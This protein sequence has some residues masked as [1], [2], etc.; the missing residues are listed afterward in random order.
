MSTGKSKNVHV[1]PNSAL[2][3]SF[4]C[5]Q[6]AD[7]TKIANFSTF[8]IY[9]HALDIVYYDKRPGARRAGIFHL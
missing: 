5:P 7:F 8:C 3:R 1:S 4:H 9:K 6:K 2:S